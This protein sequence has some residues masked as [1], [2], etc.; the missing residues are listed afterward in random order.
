MSKKDLYKNVYTAL[1]IIVKKNGNNPNVNQ[2][3]NKQTNFG[4]FIEV[5][6]TQQ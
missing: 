2:Q 6:I 1:F 5:N 3:E 4:I